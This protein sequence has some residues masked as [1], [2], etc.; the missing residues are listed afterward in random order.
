MLNGK[1]RAFLRSEASRLD[2]IFQVG[3]GG[4][5]E[6]AVKSISDALEARELVK[7]SVLLNAEKD[8]RETGEDLAAGC[9]AELVA[10]IGRKVILYRPSSKPEKRRLSS[11][12]EGLGKDKR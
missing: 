1:Q 4:V 3:K 11:L 2:A 7:V 8:P 12:L 10:V 5:G 9:C 6:A